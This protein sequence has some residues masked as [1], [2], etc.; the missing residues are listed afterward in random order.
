MADTTGAQATPKP[1]D[2]MPV[3]VLTGFRQRED[4]AA[5]PVDAA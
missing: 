5:C 1:A 4:D 2:R 3:S